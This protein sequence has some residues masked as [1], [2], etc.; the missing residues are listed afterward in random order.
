MPWSERQ[1]AMLRE[2]GLRVWQPAAAV[3]ASAAPSRTAEAGAMAPPVGWG[4]AAA[5]P[6]PDMP[7]PRPWA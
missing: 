1:R 4:P 3:P 2:M 6:M 5:A 7:G